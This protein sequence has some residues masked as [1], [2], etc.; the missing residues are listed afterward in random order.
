MYELYF[1]YFFMGVFLGGGLMTALAA[2][3]FN[4]DINYGST[5]QDCDDS[6]CASCG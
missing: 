3:I 2:F 5:K 1:W 6:G 4:I